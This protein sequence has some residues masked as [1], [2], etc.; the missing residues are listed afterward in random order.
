MNFARIH[1]DEQGETH[2][3]VEEIPDLEIPFGPRQS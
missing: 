1:A 3:G 2:F